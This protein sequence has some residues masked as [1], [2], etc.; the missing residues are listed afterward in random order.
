MKQLALILLGM[1]FEWNVVAQGTVN[2]ATRV[3]GGVD[4]PV[5]DV[6]T[7]QNIGND[8][9]GQL[10][11][12]A[13]GGTLNPVG[14]P[15]EFRNDAGIGYITAGG[16]VAIPGVA[17]GSAAQVQLVAWHK[18][19]GPDFL[20]A[21]AAGFGLWGESGIISLPQTGN[22]DAIPPTP[23]ANLLGLQGFAVSSLIPE[24]SVAA[25]VLIGGCSLLSWIDSRKPFASR[26]S[27]S[28]L[29]ESTR[30]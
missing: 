28:V 9:W 2:F 10:F 5:W 23:A 7:G 27:E 17:G 13:P 29:R 8:F 15:V 21:K 20:A 14:V 24:P 22:P 18:S 30:I 4:A 19:L 26:P 11:A 12:G 16:A 1:M 25:M 6:V 3:T